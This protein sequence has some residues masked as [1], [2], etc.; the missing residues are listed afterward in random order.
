MGE[1]QDINA[2]YSCV[3]N[4]QSKMYVEATVS[5]ESLHTLLNQPAMNMEGEI[6]IL[7]ALNNK[8]C[9]HQQKLESIVSES[10]SNDVKWHLPPLQLSQ[11]NS[12]EKRAE[13][14]IHSKNDSK[15][16]LKSAT[17]AL[18]N[19]NLLDTK[20]RVF[21]ERFLQY[22]IQ[23]IVSNKSTTVTIDMGIKNSLKTS[24]KLIVTSAT[25]K[26]NNV[27]VAPEDMFKKFTVVINHLNTYLLDVEVTSKNGKYTLMKQLGEIVA[28]DC[29]QLIIDKCLAP[30]IPSSGKDLD[31][32]RKVVDA[33]SAFQKYLME[34]GFLTDVNS[35]LTDFV[36]NVN[37]LFANKQCKQ[38]LEKA[39]D[40]MTS[41]IHSMIQVDPATD[42]LPQLGIGG[43]KK[44]KI[45]ETIS[46]PSEAKLSSGIFKM[47]KC[48]I[49]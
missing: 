41:E 27:A 23:P 38:I 13:L 33:T 47:P 15:Q 46:L 31:G 39:R 35:S 8:Y 24:V 22:F 9:Q 12:T 40:L 37:V 11:S 1:G 3:Q 6:Q 32:F 25:A 45:A 29:L 18:Y 42:S 14:H 19:L 17:Q 16:L 4:L 34:I 10:W 2:Y 20:L 30:A 44:A 43:S 36:G 7:K 28:T 5:L 26:S 49:R 21:S 48:Y